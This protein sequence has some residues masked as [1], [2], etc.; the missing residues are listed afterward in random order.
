MNLYV[1][2]IQ[3]LKVGKNNTKLSIISLPEINYY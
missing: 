2:E 1:A 3:V